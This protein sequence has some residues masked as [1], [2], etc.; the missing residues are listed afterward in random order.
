MGH[1]EQKN[2]EVVFFLLLPGTSRA[3][4]VIIIMV[5]HQ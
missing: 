3:K 5:K 4:H 2:Y 1:P